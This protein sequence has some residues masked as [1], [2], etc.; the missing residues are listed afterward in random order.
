MGKRR[1]QVASS[2][3][4]LFVE[5]G[6]LKSEPRRGWAKKLRIRHPESVADHSY[7]MAL[8]AMVL[9]DIAGLDSGR[10]AKIA[11]LHDLPEALVGDLMPGE[12]TPSSKHALETRAMKRLLAGLPPKLKEE[13]LSYYLDYSR[14]GSREA[15]L[16]KQVDKIEMAIQAW[17]Y[18]RAGSDAK[19]VRD[20]VAS[21]R[22][23][24]LDHE[25][26]ALL[27]EFAV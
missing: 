20:F 22:A 23:G 14:R 24:V 13:Y 18:A 17:E 21:A 5:S 1:S 4:K 3:A 8:M 15:R 2:I 10:A 25:L 7:R 27:E 9:S 12:R 16:V 6:R 11:L 19:L 26:R